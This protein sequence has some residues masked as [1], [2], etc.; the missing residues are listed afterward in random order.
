MAE[1][2]AY[3]EGLRVSWKRELQIGDPVRILIM[4]L[5]TVKYTYAHIMFS[6]IPNALIAAGKRWQ[7][8]ED[9]KERKK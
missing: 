5:A 1:K 4:T 2:M 6:V 7:A 8:R 9:A 3:W